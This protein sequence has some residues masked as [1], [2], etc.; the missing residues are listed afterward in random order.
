L[1][2]RI[3]RVVAVGDL[4]ADLIV[5]VPELPI[6]ADDFQLAEA[7]TLEPGGS[8]NLLILLSRL[9]TRAAALGI[10]GT[11]LW[12][13]QVIQILEEEGIEVSPINRQGTTTVA[14][15]LVDAAGHHS[16]VGSFGKGE[17]MMLG[18]REKAAVTEADALF[19]SG[20]SLREARLRDLTLD[21]LEYAG[22]R[23]KPR[24]FDPGPAFQ[25]VEAKVRQRALASSDV[26]LITEEEL[27]DLFPAGPEA[28]FNRSLTTNFSSAA[29]ATAC[30]GPH[31]VVVKRGAAGCRVFSGRDE[32]VDVP[33][34]TVTVR[35]T[36]AAGDCFDAGFLLTYLKGWSPVD[37]VRLANCAGAAAVQKVGGGRNI[38]TVK[39]VRWMIS[40][41]SFGIEI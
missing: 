39:E 21:A 18:D 26:L 2:N 13:E 12:G 11:D 24:F 22:R 15:V 5:E 9:G 27:R 10:L 41:A 30:A 37:C 17:P 29:C 28:L 38:P 16:F 34:L 7:I 32:R 4:T 25:S 20:Y 3:P 14:L 8:A 35:D 40:Q 36:T 33:G 31:T 6:T 19:A 23:G 1:N